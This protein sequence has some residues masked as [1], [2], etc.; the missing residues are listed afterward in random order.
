MIKRVV[1]L[2]PLFL[3]FLFQTSGI[4]SANNTETWAKQVL[5]AQAIP[6]PERGEVGIHTFSDSCLQATAA[7][8]PIFKPPYA[9]ELHWTNTCQNKVLDYRV[10]TVISNPL[11]N[12]VYSGVDEGRAGR[13][14]ERGS[15][16]FACDGRSQ[17]S[18]FGEKAVL[19][20]LY[21]AEGADHYFKVSVYF[22]EMAAY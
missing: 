11:G 14:T 13:C 18:Y 6:S 17:L 4:A 19:P 3:S 22:D 10:V 21:D 15:E 8:T 1:L 9:L 2:S 20:A 5:A 16:G 12:I 7:R